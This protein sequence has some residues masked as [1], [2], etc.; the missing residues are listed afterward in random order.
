MQLRL[1]P[2]H[3]LLGAARAFVVRRLHGRR[4]DLLPIVQLLLLDLL[5]DLQLLDGVLLASVRGG[6]ILDAALLLMHAQL[7][8]FLL[9]LP[10][11]LVLV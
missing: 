8:G 7:Q 6:T 3:L 9:L 11:Q 2:L 10:L 5:V 1:L 4:L